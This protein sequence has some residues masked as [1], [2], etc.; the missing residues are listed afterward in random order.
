MVL[1]SQYP[2]G[3]LL[4]TYISS[5]GPD[6]VTTFQYVFSPKKRLSCLSEVSQSI[7]SNRHKSVKTVTNF[8]ILRLI[9]YTHLLCFQENLPFSTL[10]SMWH[11]VQHFLGTQLL[12]KTKQDTFQSSSLV[13]CIY[14]RG[15]TL[16]AMNYKFSVRR[17]Q[18]TA[19]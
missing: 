9:S 11:L 8:Y 18:S 10:W 17:K 14:V 2:W 19:L 3:N 13:K 7:Q 16:Y 1:V 6:V 5:M 4:L 12:R 15:T